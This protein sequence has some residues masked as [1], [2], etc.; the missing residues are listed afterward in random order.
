MENS[1]KVTKKEY[2]VMLKEVVENV[3]EKEKGVYTLKDMTTG[4]QE[5]LTKEEVLEKIKNI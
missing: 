3:D 2:Y 1:K 4:E 5:T